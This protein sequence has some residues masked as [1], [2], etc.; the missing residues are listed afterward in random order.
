MKY[1]FSTLNPINFFTLFNKKHKDWYYRMRQNI[2][3]GPTIIFHRYHE[4]GMTRIRKGPTECA[5]VVGYDADALYLLSLMQD[6][7]TGPYITRSVKDHFKPIHAY[8]H[9]ETA[10]QWLDWLVHSESISIQHQFNR[11]ER[12]IGVRQ[13]PVDGYCKETKSVYQFHGCYFH[14]HRCH[15]N[16]K[17][18]NKTKNCFM[19]ELHRQT[20]ETSKYIKAEGYN[21]VQVW[22]CEWLEL[23]QTNSII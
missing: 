17:T 12:R 10:V 20:T 3:G 13:I 22:E 2:I 1:L 5:D 8:G 11:K 23:I 7:P 19:E 16:N 4:A 14:G 15:L 21:L 18:F 6:M 9:G